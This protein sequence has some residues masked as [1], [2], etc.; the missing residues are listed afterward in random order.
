M[1]PAHPDLFP[2][3]RLRTSLSALSLPLASFVLPSPRLVGM[4]RV[5]V[6]VNGIYFI[7]FYLFYCSFTEL[8]RKKGMSV[9]KCKQKGIRYTYKHVGAKGL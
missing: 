1:S 5:N 4:S 6:G 9:V 2:F 8:I 3:L 7:L